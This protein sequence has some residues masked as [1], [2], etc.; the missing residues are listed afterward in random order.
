[1]K[2]YYLT[3]VIVIILQIK[4]SHAQVAINTNGNDPDFSAILDIQSTSKGLLIP[5]L[6]TSERD[7]IINPAQGLMVYDS[8]TSSFWYYSNSVWNKVGASAGAA[9]LNELL[10]V[11]YDGSSLFVGAGSGEND[12][13]GNYN[14]S[15][16]N[17]SLSSN[18][19]GYGNTAL[20]PNSLSSNTTGFDNTS[21]G[22]SSLVNNTTGNV[23]IAI[24]NYSLNANTTGYDNIAIGY[25]SLNENVNGLANIALG[26]YAGQENVNGNGNTML[27]IGSNQFNQHG[28]QNTIIGYQAGKGIANHDKSGNIFIGYQ[29]GFNETGDNKLYIE[30][31]NSATPLIGGDFSADIVEINGDIEISGTIKIEGGTPG[32]NKI[33]TSDADGVAS[34]EDND[35]ASEVNEL[36]DAIYDGSSIFIGENSGLN[37]DGGNTNSSIGKSSLRLNT[38]GSYN[39]AIGNSSMYVNTI[40]SNN[41]GLGAFSLYWNTTGNINIAIGRSS[42]YFNDSGDANASLGIESLKNN[43]TGSFNT[44]IGNYAGNQNTN[45]YYNTLIGFNSNYYN[46]SGSR[47]TIIGYEAGTGS[48]LHNKTGN[49][50]IGY[51]AGFNETGDNKLYIENSNSA[52]PLIGGNFSTDL[53][54]LNGDVE[55]AGT[56][57][58]EGGGPGANKILTSDADG[59]ASWEIN[60]AASEINDLSDAIYDG[61]SLFLGS[62]SGT[63]DDGSNQNIGVGKYSLQNNTDGFMNTATGVYTLQSNAS[64]NNNTAFGNSALKSVTSGNFNTAF[65]S[66]ALYYN[67][68]DE[69]TASGY[70]ALYNNSSGAYNTASGA[71][72][73]ES[74]VAGHYNT[75]FGYESLNSVT[76]TDYNTALGARTLTS[77]TGERNT[78]VGYYSMHQNTTGNYNTALGYRTGYNNLSGSYN[79]FFGYNAR[80]GG[81]SYNN[82]TAIGNDAL[83]TAS[84]QVRIGNASVTSIGGYANWS[85]LSDGRFKLNVDENVAGLDFILKLRPV[86]YS[87][88]IEKLNTFLGSESNVKTNIQ[89]LR[90]TGFI[91]QEVEEAA[92]ESNYE[93]SGVDAPEND[94]DHYSLRYSEF[95]VPLVKA[96]QELSKQNEEQARLFNELK[97]RL[98]E[99]ENKK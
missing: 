29:A 6:S 22:A 10:D 13:G 97:S 39:V 57:K 90:R 68:G 32:A 21:I 20:G 49:I 25:F 76:S 26:T 7:A 36:S 4:T 24:G 67:T 52:T 91:A 31:S 66:Q 63:A 59:N 62:Q 18:T 58:I 46:Q 33:L 89:E 17:N 38:T 64:G 48:A 42:M 23:N 47:N 14:I 93:F 60:T 92:M 71:Y 77:S 51:Q 99:L 65:G 37:D 2:I 78:A 8:T 27:G 82:S 80:A 61:S 86:N 30:N 19:A 96:V 34:W 72:S 83:I 28:S 74:L 73:S 15:M 84:N 70:K 94:N 1:M 16:G 35:S 85:N 54:E 50:F 87:I 43:S 9:E 81:S 75:A 44:A 5:R 79:T 40:G 12:D 3:L 53:V 88:D 41:I 55:I 56:L 69:N 98:D 95:V 45:G 11:I